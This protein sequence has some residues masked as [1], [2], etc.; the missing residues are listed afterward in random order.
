MKVYCKNCGGNE[1]NWPY[2]GGHPSPNCLRDV[3]RPQYNDFTDEKEL[4][5]VRVKYIQNENGTCKYYKRK[6][7]KFWIKE[8]GE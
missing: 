1:S 6:W 4:D 7:W 5:V 8:G 3:S 2:K